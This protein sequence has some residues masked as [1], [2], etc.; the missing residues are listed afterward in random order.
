MPDFPVPRMNP[1]THRSPWAG[2]ALSQ[3][4]G[5]ALL[6]TCLWWVSREA[7]FIFANHRILAALDIREQIGSL[8]GR[9][10][11]AYAAAAWLIH[12]LL[13]LAAFALARLTEAAC[14][15][16]TIGRREWLICGWFAVLTGLAFAA[17]TTWLRSSLFAGEESW[18]RGRYLGIAPVSIAVLLVALLITAFIIRA[19]PRVH[20]RPLRPAPIAVAIVSLLA[21]TAAFMPPLDRAEGVPAPGTRPHIVLIGIDSLRNDLLVPRKG[22][23]QAPNIREF[24]GQ[25]RRFSDATSPLARTYPAWVSILTGRHPVATNARY[26]LMPRRL[27]RE[28]ETLGDALHSRGYRTIYSTDEVRFANIDHSFGFDQL[29]TPPI[30]AADFIL[31]YAGDIPLVNLVASMPG[32]GRLFPSNHANRAA[33]VTYHPRHFVQRLEN[34]LAIEGPTLIAIHLTLAHWPYAWAGQAVPTMP[35]D[36]RDAYGKAVTEVDRQFRDVLAALES[37]HV[38]DNAIVVLLS[39]HGEALGADSDSMFRGTGTHREIWDSLWGHGTS[40][41]SPNQYHV[42]LAMRAFGRARLP[43]PERNYD[44]PVSLEDLRPTLEH[45]ATGRIPDEVD[46]LSL[47]PY[48]DNPDR[49]GELSTR[50]RFTE[51]DFNTPKTLEG[52]YEASG[53][54]DEAALY[55]EVDRESAWVQF[56]ADRLPE[57]F[58]RKQR[59]AVSAKSF[60]AVIPRPDGQGLQYLFTERSKPAP[61]ALQGPPDPSAEPEA[62]LLWDALHSRFPEAADHSL[63]P[64][65]DVKPVKRLQAAVWEHCG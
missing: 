30:G 60:L 32:G 19:L 5:V 20:L 3:L 25:S 39:D 22:P 6:A 31:G 16:R 37:K 46:G 45:F 40:V 55:Y 9:Q 44:W 41:M 8:L 24:L 64:G 33:N 62:R 2:F 43:G 53:L 21:L 42:L 50:I 14:R 51:T 10:L 29:I 15:G 52:R 28:G 23:A 59:A 48:F 54:V 35:D 38:L 4:L 18:W 12:A 13:G 7:G 56:R 1:E 63:C 57:L 47:L 65:P 58:A 34:E 17:N 36:Y 61:R 26:N 11:A 27:V 49:A